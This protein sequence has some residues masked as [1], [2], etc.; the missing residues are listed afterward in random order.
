MTGMGVEQSHGGQADPGGFGPPP[1]PF[2]PPPAAS[3]FQP[4]P[5][6]PFQ[7]AVPASPPPPAPVAPPYPS[8]PATPLD[9]PEFL[10]ADPDNGVAVGPEGVHF[11]QGVYAA[12]FP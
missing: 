11:E 7:P 6:A 2:A 5:P 4:A 1:P 10:A 9:G 12:D 8:A 3:S